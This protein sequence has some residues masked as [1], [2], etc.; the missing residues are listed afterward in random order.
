MSG[1]ETEPAALRAGGE[2]VIDVAE[3]FIGQLES[4]EAQMAGYGEPWGGDD[5]GSLIGTVYVGV[6]AWV[7]DCIGVAAEEIGAAGSDLTLMADNYESVEQESAD[8][9]LG[10]HRLL[11]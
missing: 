4:F 7:L 5:I 9:M 2:Q 1:F 11:G 6:S 3:R 8:A 10:I